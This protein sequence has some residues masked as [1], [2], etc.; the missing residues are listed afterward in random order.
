MQQGVD[1]SVRNFAVKADG[2]TFEKQTKKRTSHLDFVLEPV[3]SSS[4]SVGHPYK[5]SQSGTTNLE[6]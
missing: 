3:V 2:V 6:V 5:S 4:P 1:A